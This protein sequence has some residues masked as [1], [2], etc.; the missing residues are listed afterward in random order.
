MTSAFVAVYLR[1]MLLL[2]RRLKR[3][4]AGMAVSPVLYL[5]TFGYAL[6]GDMRV[7]GHPYLVFLLPG[8]AAMSSMTQA[9][10]MASEINIARFY[11]G[12]FEEIQA[13]PTGRLAYAGGEVCAGLTRVILAVSMILGLGA[14]FGVRMHCGVQFWLAV[15][16]NGAAFS[17]LAVALAMLIKSHADQA[18]LNNFVI[19][20]MAFLGGT[21]FPLDELPEWL[22]SVLFFL[23]LSHASGAIRAAALDLPSR[24][25]SLIVLAAAAIAFFLFALYAVG[26]AKD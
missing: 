26:L 15:L 9:F 3:V 21:F 2:R 4:L 7:G 22:R 11:S 12:V 10:A 24:P 16:L 5:I 19:T 23:P 1:E 6:G 14:L 25:Q 17:S 13:A 20:P 18:L 8:L